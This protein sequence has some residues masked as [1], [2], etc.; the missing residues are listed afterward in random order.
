M[1]ATVIRIDVRQSKSRFPLR[2]PQRWTWTATNLGNFEV[3]ARSSESYTNEKDCEAA[4]VVLFSDG[5]RVKLVGPNGTVI[6]RE[7]VE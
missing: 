5:A 2:R 4:A 7:M 6:L 1:S 3:M